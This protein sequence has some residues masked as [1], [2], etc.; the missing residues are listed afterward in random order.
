M[1][2]LLLVDDDP[3]NRRLFQRVLEADGHDVEAVAGGVEALDVVASGLVDLV[4]TDVMMPGMDGWE[5]AQRLRTNPETALLPVIFLTSLDDT[6]D[7]A[8]GFQLGADDYIPKQSGVAEVRSRVERALAKRGLVADHATSAMRQRTGMVGDLSVLGLSALLTMCQL[9]GKTGRLS[10]S[11]DQDVVEILLRGGDVVDAM[12]LDGAGPDTG[13]DVIYWAL[14]WQGGQFFLT[15]GA[16]DEPDV[17]GMSTMALLMEGARRLDEV[18][19]G[20]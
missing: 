11:R 15:A 4:I 19:R 7:H 6:A 13:H 8:H 3:T 17:I 5:L 1:A 10:L 12:R 16:V 20:G 9:E 14:T 2:V 18:Q